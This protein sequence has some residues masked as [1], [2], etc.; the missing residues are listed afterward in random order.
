MSPLGCA[1]LP[2]TRSVA[3]TP[4]RSS[5]GI[6]DGTGDGCSLRACA[7]GD[8]GADLQEGDDADRALPVPLLPRGLPRPGQRRL[9]Q[10]ADAARAG[11]QRHGLRL[12]RRH[13]LPGLRAVRG[14]EQRGPA[15]GRRPAVDRADHDHLGADLR[16]HG[17]RPDAAHL[18]RLAF[19]ARR[20][21]GRVHPGHP[22]LSHLLVSGQSARADHRDIPRGDPDGQHFRRPAVRLDP[23]GG[24]RRPWPERLAVAVPA[25]DHSLADPGYRHAVLP[26]RSCRLGQ[27]AG[28]RRETHRRRKY[29]LRRK[30]K[31]V[32]RTSPPPSGLAG[33]GCSG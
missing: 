14:A 13:L 31:K 33:S 6:K 5:G 21:R 19:P 1:W 25:G 7:A 10:A 23:E 30:T 29:R 2:P 27:V 28:R 22:A 32:S 26:R 20:R 24:Q 11:F 3:A 4:G 12:R 9:R 16:R 18:L 15:P 8:G 17:L